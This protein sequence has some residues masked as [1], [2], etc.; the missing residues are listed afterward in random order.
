MFMVAPKTVKKWADRYRTEASRAW[1]TAARGHPRIRPRPLPSSSVGS[2]GCAGA[3]GSAR[4]ISPADRG[5]RP[6]PCTPCWCAAG[7]TAIDRAINGDS[8][9]RLTY[10][11]RAEAVRRLTDRGHSIRTIAEQLATSTRTVSRHR[12][13]SRAA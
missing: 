12:H 5:C 3:T 9:V 2:C 1:P 10:A 8:S 6:R 4:S 11:E 13:P 7:S